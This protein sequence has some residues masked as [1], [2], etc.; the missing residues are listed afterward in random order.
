MVFS[1]YAWPN[2]EDFSQ[3]QLHDI[4]SIAFHKDYSTID[5]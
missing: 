3:L 5:P 1:R 2:L 4:C